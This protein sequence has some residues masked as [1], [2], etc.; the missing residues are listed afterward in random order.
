V[1]A[2]GKENNTKASNPPV[3]ASSKKFTIMK[4]RNSDGAV[5]AP[6]PSLP[7]ARTAGSLPSGVMKAMS[8]GFGNQPIGSARPIPGRTA[9]A[10][11]A[12][13]KRPAVAPKPAAMDATH[14]PKPFDATHTKPFDATLTGPFDSTHSRPF[15]ATHTTPF[16]A[17]HRPPAAAA[18]AAPRPVVATK[19]PPPQP[20]T[21]SAAAVAAAEVAKAADLKKKAT[22]AAAT[23]A[24]ARA[25]IR[26]AQIAAA[27]E[28]WANTI[29]NESDEDDYS[30]A[31][32]SEE[33]EEEEIVV[34]VKTQAEI[35]EEE[36]V[37]RVKAAKQAKFAKKF[38]KRASICILSPSKMPGASKVKT[39]LSK[40]EEPKK[41]IHASPLR[42]LQANT[43]GKLAAAP[44]VP[45]AAA[46]PIRPQPASTTTKPAATTQHV[47]SHAKATLLQK[48]ADK[49]FSSIE[50]APRSSSIASATPLTASQ[51][52]R[53]GWTSMQPPPAQIKETAAATPSV[54]R[55]S[56]PG[57]D[58]SATP[59]LLNR[60]AALK[61]GA[62][63]KRYPWDSPLV[64]SNTNRTHSATT[65]G[66][67]SGLS[68]VNATPVQPTQINFAT[69]ALSA[70][71]EPADF[72]TPVQS[73]PEG[74][75]CTPMAAHDPQTPLSDATPIQ[76]SKKF[77]NSPFVGKLGRMM[78]DNDEDDDSDVELE[79]VEDSPVA[80]AD[81]AYRIAEEREGLLRM[82]TAGRSSMVTPDLPPAMG[83]LAT[84]G[85][86]DSPAVEDA[87]TPTT[88][89][90]DAALQNRGFLAM[91][92]FFDSPTENK[93]AAASQ[94]QQQEVNS[95][96]GLAK[97]ETSTVPL[98]E[99]PISPTPDLRTANETPVGQEPSNSPAQLSMSALKAEL[100]RMQDS[101]TGEAVKALN[102]E[103]QARIEA[104]RLQTELDEL[105]AQLAA[106]ELEE[107]EAQL[108]ATELEEIE[109]QLAATELEEIEAQLAATELEE[110]AEAT[111]PEE[112]LVPATPES[113]AALET[114]SESW[115]DI[116][117]TASPAPAV[118]A[119]DSSLASGDETL[120]NVDEANDSTSKLSMSAIE[121]EMARL[122][123]DTPPNVYEDE[124]ECEETVVENNASMDELQMQI[125]AVSL[126]GELFEADVPIIAGEVAMYDHRETP[127]MA[128]HPPL[129]QSTPVATLVLAAP[130]PTLPAD[131]STPQL[132][133]SLTS[134]TLASQN[135]DQQLDDGNVVE[136]AEVACTPPSPIVAEAAVAEIIAAEPP[137][138]AAAP[139]TL[140]LFIDDLQN[141]PELA[142]EE[143][144][145]S[146]AESSA[147]LATEQ[148]AEQ[149]TVVEASQPEEVA[150]V[151][152]DVAPAAPAPEEPAAEEGGGEQPSIA[153]E[154]PTPVVEEPAEEEGPPLDEMSLADLKA[155][156]KSL[157]LI[158][159]NGHKG[160]KATWIAALIAYRRSA[161]PS[162]N[163]QSGGD[164][165]TAAAAVVVAAAA[166]SAAAATDSDMDGNYCNVCKQQL[167]NEKA[168][169][170]HLSTKKHAKN[171]GIRDAELQELANGGADEAAEE[172]VYD[173]EALCECRNAADGTREFLVK[174][175]GFADS[176]NSWESEASINVDL[177]K[178]F[179][180]TMADAA[181][182]SVDSS[183]PLG[184]LLH[185]CGQTEVLTWL[186]ALGEKA[187]VDIGKVGEG[188]FAEVFCGMYNGNVTAFKV[189]PFDGT[190][191][192]NDEAM[193]TSEELVPEVV[194]SVELSAL[195][196]S[197]GKFV[198]SN[199]IE[200]QGVT[201]CSGAYPANLLAEWS[202]WDAENQSEN[203]NPTIFGEDQLFIV[204]AF[205][206]G[207]IDLES[208][209]FDNID[210]AKS[211]LRQLCV[212]LAVAEKTL[213]FEHRDLHWGNVLLR[214]CTE[215]SIEYCLGGKKMS[216]ETHG[217]Y[218]SI[219]DFTLSRLERR[220]EPFFF[221]LE[222]DECYFE[223]EGDM[224][225]DVYR[226]MRKCCKKKW[227]KH[228]PRTNL[229][230]IQ[231][232]IDKVLNE[233]NYA[234]GDGTE[235]QDAELH[236][237][238][239]SILR[240]KSMSGA[241]KDKFFGF[242]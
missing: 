232:L 83:I 209:E 171:C 197:S 163:A 130:S 86:L 48:A 2:K 214:E 114:L 143:I 90:P 36:R 15:D 113:P 157:D 112:T 124:V 138:T 164:A 92:G 91:G 102:E 3:A 126:V 241:L 58:V 155:M 135:D 84:G 52:V 104:E 9:A 32:E 97:D 185:T 167:K 11:A 158:D 219:I 201:I 37:D 94:Q 152:L 13:M 24:A 198:A 76:T 230:W 133:K 22:A 8:S 122:S 81:H 222:S 66:A 168:V 196:K 159:V 123:N 128:D 43:P 220:G 146:A 150:T 16:D 33:G 202:A 78:L 35:E 108:A 72:A 26:A 40:F 49:L 191:L 137:S 12:P 204:F 55:F 213:A 175:E 179:D 166:P 95:A 216:V 67:R 238:Y 120:L 134:S 162:T 192:V 117:Y 139:L 205:A 106:S 105:D 161:A 1:G 189:M 85:F 45:A 227:S 225:F 169:A 38:K 88:E 21:K 87:A 46:A 121:A 184:K 98:C 160:K 223:G 239:K 63:L 199:F 107:I 44:M 18:P 151:D 116:D 177:V 125:Q 148:A 181:A 142:T 229:Y 173:V 101:P 20:P 118:A 75:F 234:S 193:K 221:D 14:R 28:T 235:D 174:W 236:A 17:T 180:E 7:P 115:V 172:Q 187:S 57:T 211:M 30:S 51:H 56:I 212:S 154:P 182:N 153:I 96:Q 53:Q 226:S 77:A 119:I 99:N 178:V 64:P 110:P 176:A 144:L 69:P 39:M 156:A 10:A 228:H 140:S 74:V 186:D 89:T 6:P 25:A 80:A 132:D 170:R 237:F 4:I 208:F 68:S 203:E 82:E 206:N 210:Q 54:P 42:K 190:M 240:Y 29:L 111:E 224:Q 62:E 149:P 194:A 50:Q 183:T 23:A 100:A 59:S 19:A 34:P 79:D 109:A 127:I 129:I 165:P 200:L 60:E 145:A 65:V 242:K 233:K 195:G 131:R 217:V 218:S 31:D 5:T 41:A 231:Y 27:N 47:P 207:G 103:E 188:T 71:E 141:L 70:A 136:R 215:S 147:E 93:A 61:P 73:T